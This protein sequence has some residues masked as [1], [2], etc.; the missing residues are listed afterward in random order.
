[1]PLIG[2]IF[3]AGL[4][5]VAAIGI[6]SR[7]LL[8]AI[9]GGLPVKELLPSLALPL[10]CLALS[11]LAPLLTLVLY[12]L[13]FPREDRMTRKLLETAFGANAFLP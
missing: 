3:I 4:I 12:W 6:S 7:S 10:R 5:S 13:A 8:H 2:A 1:M 11:A 9:A